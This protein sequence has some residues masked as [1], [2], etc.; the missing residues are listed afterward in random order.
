MAQIAAYP[1][2]SLQVGIGNRVRFRPS[3]LK[4]GD[5][6]LAETRPGSRDDQSSLRRHQRPRESALPRSIVPWSIGSVDG[7]A[8]QTSIVAS[9]P[10]PAPL[11]FSNFAIS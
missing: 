7:R 2:E 5:P 10:L 3:C 8:V 4:F 1:V 6:A 9:R 11:K